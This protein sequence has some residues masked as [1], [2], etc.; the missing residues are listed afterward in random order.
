M[1]T[2][3]HL[4][5]PAFI[6]AMEKLKKGIDAVLNGPRLIGAKPAV[7]FALLAFPLDGDEC[8][9][10]QVTNDLSK[11]HL[12]AVLRGAAAQHCPIPF[13]IRLRV[14]LDL[15][16]VLP[17]KEQQRAGAITMAIVGYLWPNGAKQ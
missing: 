7:G 9:C 1:I 12:A 17:E 3:E 13:V 4:H 11:E 8:L 10:A 6:A 15:I 14:V 16:E 5:H 2:N